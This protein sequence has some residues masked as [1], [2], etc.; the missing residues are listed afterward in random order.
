MGSVKPTINTPATWRN[1]FIVW[2]VQQM[3]WTRGAELGVWKGDTYLHLLNHC[4]D[5]TLYGVDLWAPQPGHQGPEDW[6]EWDHVAHEKRVRDGAISHGPR[7]KIL[8]MLTGEAA[9]HVDDGSLDF[10]FIDADHSTQGVTDDIKTWAPKLNEEGWL[11]GHD[12]DW[13]SVREAVDALLPGYEIGPNVVWFRPNNP[14]PGWQRWLK[15]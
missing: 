8:K 13:P 4:P 3:G 7:A 9:E 11:I 1:T 12:I 6:V 15:P 10:V 2:L 14:G 5:L